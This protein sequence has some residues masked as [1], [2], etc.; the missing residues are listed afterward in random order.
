MTSGVVG[1]GEGACGRVPP[2]HVRVRR[3]MHVCGQVHGYECERGQVPRQ[4]RQ[5]PAMAW[6]AVYMVLKRGDLGLSSWVPAH[7]DV[8]AWP[9]WSGH[10]MWHVQLTAPTLG[11]RTRQ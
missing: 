8:S 9:I 3:R 6:H 2:G 11:S 10:V 4:K 5:L 1:R 7:H